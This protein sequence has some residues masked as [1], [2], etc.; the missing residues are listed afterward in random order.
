[1]GHRNVRLIAVLN[2]DNLQLQ[3]LRP[4]LYRIPADELVEM[5]GL[6]E[7]THPGIKRLPVSSNSKLQK[8]KDDPPA[9]LQHPL[10]LL[11]IHIR[12]LVQE[13]GK[14][15]EETDHVGPPP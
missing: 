9:R 15:R 1:M 10:G 11:Q 13:M 12:L 14:D 3:V 8:A 2:I 4:R 6:V 7:R 5:R